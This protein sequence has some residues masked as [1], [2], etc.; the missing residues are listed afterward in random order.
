M[1]H[2]P[3]PR[4]LG[5]IASCS[6]DSLHR[7]RCAILGLNRLCCGCQTITILLL[8]T[9]PPPPA[10]AAAPS[11]GVE[12]STAAPDGAP[13]PTSLLAPPTLSSLSM[14]AHPRA[15]CVRSGWCFL[16]R[17][18]V[19]CVCVFFPI[20]SGRQNR[21]KYQPGS[22]RTSHPP[23]FCG[24]TCLI[25]SRGK[26]SAIPFPRRQVEFLHTND[27]IV[28]HLLGIYFILFIYLVRVGGWESRSV[29]NPTSLPPFSF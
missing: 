11:F 9:A 24:G 28:L 6:F 14:T 18:V 16:R 23:S 12:G 17:I 19:L 25:F 20:Y 15:C 4:P 3:N 2:L 7:D 29:L 1:H 22:H 13:P 5:P 10:A 27:L 26:D 8:S 21:W